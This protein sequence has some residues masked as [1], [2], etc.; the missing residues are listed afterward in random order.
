MLVLILM[1]KDPS[2]VL[3]NGILILVF[4]D[5]NSCVFVHRH[6]ERLGVVYVNLDL[7]VTGTVN[8]S[9]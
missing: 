3:Y 7:G 2:M 5:G 1:L 9:I 4:Y 6:V 8:G